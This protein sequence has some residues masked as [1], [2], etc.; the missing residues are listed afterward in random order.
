MRYL[1]VVL[2]AAGVAGAVAAGVAGV[3]AAGAAAGA[4]GAVRR[5]VSKPAAESGA[6]QLV[7]EDDFD[8]TALNASNW[9]VRQNE[10]HCAPCEAELYVAS[11][12]T[13]A[14]STLII[15]TARASLVG[16]GGAPYNWSSGWVD[17]NG[18]FSAQYGLFEASVKLPARTATGIWPAFWTL[19][20]DTACWPTQGEIDIYE[21]TANPLL[22]QIYGSY[23]WGTTCGNDNQPLPGA[24]YPPLGNDTLNWND[25]FHVFGV[26][27]NATALT[28]YVDGVPYETKTSTEVILPTVAQYIIFDSAIAWYWPPDAS[29]VYPAYHVVDWV[30]VYQ[31]QA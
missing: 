10:S 20:N 24:G 25:A 7:W 16:P 8:G 21:Y 31:Q 1:C 17:T 11:A 26:E 19:P 13:V 27:W 28:F 2:V 30:R 22:N 23:R 6:W 5:P 3:A 18:K 29:A 9:N 15:T 12:V 4:A 14:N